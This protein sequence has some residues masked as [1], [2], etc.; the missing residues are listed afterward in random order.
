MAEGTIRSPSRFLRHFSW[1]YSRKT[2]SRSRPAITPPPPHGEKPR[3]PLFH[4]RPP[5]SAFFSSAI[6]RK[7]EGTGKKKLTS[8][9]NVLYRKSVFQKLFLPHT[10]RVREKKEPFHPP[11]SPVPPRFRFLFREFAPG[12]GKFKV[13]RSARFERSEWKSTDFF[14]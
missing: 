12:S 2:L 8:G 14:S 1:F 3:P 4:A 7:K 9:L 13:R 10:P 11:V 5:K 6:N